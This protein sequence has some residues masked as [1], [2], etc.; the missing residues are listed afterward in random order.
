MTLQEYLGKVAQWRKVKFGYRE[1]AEHYRKINYEFEDFITGYWFSDIAPVKA[2]EYGIECWERLGARALVVDIN[3]C[4]YRWKRLMELGRYKSDA[5]LNVLR[6]TFGYAVILAIC[7]GQEPPSMM[8]FG[9]EQP[10]VI[11]DRL[12]ERCWEQGGDPSPWDGFQM[13]YN[14]LILAADQMAQVI[15]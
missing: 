10:K 9:L 4:F 2:E 6:D 1:N 7:L 5:M 3:A 14:M 13:A 12:I 11:N 15:L 8:Y